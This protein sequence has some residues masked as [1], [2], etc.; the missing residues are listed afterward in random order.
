MRGHT[1]RLL[2]LAFEQTDPGQCK[3]R[4]K[5]SGGP[6]VWME[7]SMPSSG[8]I[9]ALMTIELL[10]CMAAFCRLSSSLALINIRGKSARHWGRQFRERISTV[11][12]VER[13]FD[14]TIYIREVLWNSH[15]CVHHSKRILMDRLKRLYV[16]R[17]NFFLLLLNFSA[18]P[19]LGPAKQDLYTF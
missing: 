2:S 1:F 10:I 5:R 18:W 4:G 7:E 8:G 12:R 9:V 14:E 13:Y 6:C 16:V 17:G 19:C 15:Y 3:Q 11:S